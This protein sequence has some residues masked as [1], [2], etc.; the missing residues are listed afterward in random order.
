MEVRTTQQQDIAR[1]LAQQF[2]GAQ[3]LRSGVSGRSGH[4]LPLCCVYLD[5]FI[6]GEVQPVAAYDHVVSCLI[7]QYLSVQPWFASASHLQCPEMV[8]LL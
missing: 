2:Y 3:E 6:A 7:V 1:R 8:R 4:G 5:V